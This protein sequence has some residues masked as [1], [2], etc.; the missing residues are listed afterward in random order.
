[1]A[2]FLEL[3]LLKHFIV[4]FPFLLVFVGTYAI[5]TKV[6][7][8]GE[9]KGINAIIAFAIASMFLF[10][11]DAVTL[12]TVLT[13]WFILAIFVIFFML[14]MFQFLGVDEKTIKEKVMEKEWGSPHWIIVAI[15]VIIT[16]A[17]LSQVY[18]PR[19]AEVEE[20][21]RVAAESKTV[22][23]DGEVVEQP[24]KFE[25]RV[26]DILFHPKVVGLILLLLIVV[27]AIRTLAVEEKEG[28][29]E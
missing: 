20:Q 14:L 11:Q 29:S 21:E 26:K 12:L 16:I 7:I 28:K 3:G 24:V 23:I 5:L 25:G 6:K 4:I 2:T 17:G 9:D 19:L 8:L 18:G 10:V 15:V 27:F 1:M 22:I 13:P